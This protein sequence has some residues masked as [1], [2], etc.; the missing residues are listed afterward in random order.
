MVIGPQLY[1]ALNKAWKSTCRILFGEEIG[2]LKE[3]ERWLS[4]FIEKA[5]V[6]KSAVSE[7][8]VYLASDNYCKDAKF[9]SFDEIDFNKRFEPLNIN[10][11]KDIDSIVESIQERVYYA[12][13]VVLGN[14]KFIEGSSNIT[15]SF[16]VYKSFYLHDS[17]YIAYSKF[18]QDSEYMFGA[19]GGNNRYMIKGISALGS[20]RCFE[21]YTITNCSD[22]YYSADL[23]ACSDCI[24][25]FC[26]KGKRRAI[27]NLELPETKYREL[28]KKLISEIVED[29]KHNKRVPSL[30]ELVSVF[31][32]EELELDVVKDEP[33][34]ISPIQRA[35]E[36]TF[37]ILFKRESQA[38]LD[39]YDIFLSKHLPG[40]R[41]V[42]G[43]SA[44]SALYQD[45]QISLNKLNR[46][47]SINESA[48]L[49]SNPT[50][51]S[52][53]EIDS[54]SLKDIS[55]LSKIAFMSL[56]AYEGKNRNIRKSALIYNATDCCCGTAYAYS[57]RCAF[58]FWPRHSS[59]LFGSSMTLNSSFCI[60]AYQSDKVTRAFQVDNC[61]NCSDVYFSHNCENVQ[62]SMF[63][64]NVKNLKNAIGNA[65]LPQDKY[66]KVKESL[67][68]QIADELIKN[69][70]FKW[71]IYNVGCYKHK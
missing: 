65:A 66:L 56:D 40:G 21:Y 10:E 25:C 46:L 43:I 23:T 28:K 29:L 37:R 35:F 19:T 55:A 44:L 63:C 53:D 60:N 38:D 27:G 31:P 39:S 16:Y 11:I 67:L 14:S 3:Y 57:N 5:R 47:I 9:I 51:L 69:K 61:N 2:E 41:V 32:Q 20:Q 18:C 36:S 8:E 68:W 34:D 54:I 59:Y 1:N 42:S 4:E 17:K 13:N 26:L 62:D 58:S 48:V 64:F 71:D 33:F 30:L 50:T 22:I 12:G 6:E 45:L 52:T 15:N 7:S 70:D 49:S 24:F